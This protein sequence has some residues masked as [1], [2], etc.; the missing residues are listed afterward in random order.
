VDALN[1]D[2][3]TKLIA[4]LFPGLA[5]QRVLA[6]AKLKQA[7]RYY[8]AV[9]PSNHRPRRGGP[10]SADTVLD[11]SRGKLR[12]YARWLDENHDLATGILNDL[13][14]N[15]VGSGVGMEP[16]ARFKDGRPATELNAQLRELWRTFW[17]WPDVTGEYSGDEL[18]QLLCRTWLRDGE[19]FLQHVIGRTGARYRSPLPYQ[20]E[21]LESDFVPFDLNGDNVIHGVQ[22]NAWGQPTGYF[23]YKR[24]PGEMR[25]T[26]DLETKFVPAE[27][28]THLKFVRRLHQTRGVSLFHSVLARLDDIKDYEESE[29]IAARIAA[30][31]T[32][33]IKRNGEYEPSPTG[34]DGA[35]LFEMEP[36]LIYDNLRPG[37]DVGLI[38]S[39]RPNAGLEPF[40]DS[41]LRAVAA[42]TNTRFSSIAKNYNGTYSAQ[43]Q[44]LIEGNLHYAALFAQF[45]HQCKLPI[46]I[47]FVDAARLSG[48]LKIP[49]NVAV[50]SLYRPEVRKA[51]LAWIDPQRESKAF[52]TFL[53]I[54]IKS[55]QQIIRD[56]GGDP[57]EVD[58]Q[59]AADP[60]WET[61]SGHLPEPEPAAAP[62]PDD[63]DPPDPDDAANDTED[64]D[65]ST[66]DRQ[67][68]QAA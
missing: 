30:A 12:D 3:L 34:D 24:H 41:Q 16:L 18:D 63:D 42:G 5:A 56:I 65:A 22:K 25:R 10:Q 37:E 66:D 47:R 6:Q 49:A 20:I 17:D 40:R 67:E 32:G 45:K 23:V 53:K 48:L 57:T 38:K 28:F 55:R 39:D 52:E 62:E 46:W 64:D 19:V 7:Q 51:G 1:M 36:G 44:E 54:G 29:R 43:R 13:V 60:L 33:F 9:A 26:L 4:P 58:T 14:I 35:R 11:R 59:I 31:L 68:A 15:I 21:V 50:E 2:R 61:V 27:R 8:D